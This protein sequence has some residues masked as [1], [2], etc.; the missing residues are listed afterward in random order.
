MIPFETV[1]GW[2]EELR[3]EVKGVNSSMMH[4][5]NICKCHNISSPSTTIKEKDRQR[6]SKKKK[7]KTSNVVTVI[8]I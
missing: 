7:K 3:R 5:K 4:C 6:E 2:G 1:P 8:L